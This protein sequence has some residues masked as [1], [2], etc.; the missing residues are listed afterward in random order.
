MRAAV[1]AFRLFLLTIL[2]PLGAIAMLWRRSREPVGGWMA[3]FFVAAGVT[4]FSFF[5]APWGVFGFPARYLL[6]ALLILASV[7]S[8]RRARREDALPES[9][10]RSLIKVLV[11]FFFGTVA[12]GVMRA[13]DV[14]PGAIELTFP[15]RDGSFVVGHGGSTSAANMYNLDPVQSYAVDV[16]QLNGAGM[17]ARG[18]YPADPHAYKIFGA[19]VFSPC[20]GAVRTVAKDSVVLHCNDADV[21]LAHLQN[22]AVQ[23]G[24]PIAHGTA[25]ARVGNA[26][27]PHLHVFASRAG[28]AVPMRFDG[29]WLVRNA[30]VRR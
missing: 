24:Q 13:H 20:D 4:A 8:L 7:F 16:M 27:E 1:A 28:H 29:K 15:L 23:P 2:L 11:G 19:Q 18:F 17:R 5:A 25:L 9:P 14:P 21:T 3:T 22:I 30:V 6:L 12:L 26:E 10:F